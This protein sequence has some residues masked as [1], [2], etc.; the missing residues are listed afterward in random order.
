MK[1]LNA[2]VVTVRGDIRGG[3]AVVSHL[4]GIVQYSRQWCLYAVELL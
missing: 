2:L 1:S 4:V 3:K